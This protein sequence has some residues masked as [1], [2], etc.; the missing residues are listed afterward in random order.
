MASINTIKDFQLKNKN[1]GGTYFDE[2]HVKALEAKY[3]AIVYG[4]KNNGY[5]IAES[6]RRDDVTEYRV[7]SFST[8]FRFDKVLGS[9]DNS[10]DQMTFFGKYK[11]K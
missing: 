4:T 11:N 8:N 2:S 5:V 7:V 9:F 3:H 6:I 1:N 10:T